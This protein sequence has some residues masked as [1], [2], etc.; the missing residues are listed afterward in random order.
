MSWWG[1]GGPS[2]TLFFLHPLVS[3]E[4]TEQ[5]LAGGEAVLC[6][7]QFIAV[8][9]FTR[10]DLLE[11]SAQDRDLNHARRRK[12][13]VGFDGD[14]LTGFE[15]P[16]VDAYVARQGVSESRQLGSKSIGRRCAL[17]PAQEREGQQRE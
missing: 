16:K 4:R 12:H 6:V 15:V 13:R 5:V 3:L 2:R 14:F 8:G 17:A 9:Q 11:Q 1:S 10:F 7:G